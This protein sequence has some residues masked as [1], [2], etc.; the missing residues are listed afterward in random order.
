MHQPSLAISLFYSFILGYLFR[1]ILQSLNRCCTDQVCTFSSPITR[2]VPRRSKL[3]PEKIRRIS[4]HSLRMLRPQH[5]TR[6]ENARRYGARRM[7][8][9]QEKMLSLVRH[10]N[11][12]M[13]SRAQGQQ[14]AGFTRRA[15][16]CYSVNCKSISYNTTTAIKVP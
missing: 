9:A 1:L 12:T 8:T 16:H 6:R 3:D 13:A 5:H 7:P 11:K 14:V 2:R 10:L 4:K 15:K